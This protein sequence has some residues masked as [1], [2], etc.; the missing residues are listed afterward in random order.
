M[1]SKYKIIFWGSS[2]FALPSL[3]ALTERGWRPLAVITQPDKPV[4]RK[5]SL[6]PT[7]VKKLAAELNLPIYSPDAANSKKTAAL[8]KKLSPDAMVVAAYGQILSSEILALPKH[9]TLN[10]HASLLPLYRGASPIQQAILE[11]VKKTGVTIMLMDEKMDHGAILS[12]QSLKI[13]PSDTSESLSAK[14]AILGGELLIQT[15]P[16]W[17]KGEVKARTQ[18]HQAATYTKI[19]NR[20]DGL[21]DWHWPSEKIERLIRAYYPWPGAYTKWRGQTL[22]IHQAAVSRVKAAAPAGQVAMG[23]DGEALVGTGEGGLALKQI[24]LAGG[25]ILAARDFLFG[26]PDFIGAKLGSS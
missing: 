2:A 21:I 4:G 14:L 26:H 10:V 13:N 6:T 22:K 16:H 9:G 17:L 23:D 5:R 3:Q 7:P 20:A 8:I 15:L 19:I 18:D 1:E 11:G 12:Q 24:Q 25:K